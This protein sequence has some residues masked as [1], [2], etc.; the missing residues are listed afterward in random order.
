M[1]KNK[2]QIAALKEELRGYEIYGK[3]KRAE[4]VK[5]EIKALGGKTENKAAKPKSEK[6]VVKK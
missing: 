1:S 5:K 6:K 2:E 4:E 3:A